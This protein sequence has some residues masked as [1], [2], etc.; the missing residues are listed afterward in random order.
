MTPSDMTSGGF[1]NWVK[2][3]VWVSLHL[4][5]AFGVCTLVL[6]LVGGSA[7]ANVIGLRLHGPIAGLVNLVWSPL[8]AGLVS[9]PLAAIAYPVSRYTRRLLSGN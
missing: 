5:F 9:L 6:S 2:T 8:L 7:H 3:C 4:G 1:L